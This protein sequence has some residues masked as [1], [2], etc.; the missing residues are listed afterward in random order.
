[1]NRSVFHL[2]GGLLSLF[3]GNKFVLFQSIRLLW[4]LNY[5]IQT[6]LTFPN[7]SEVYFY[8]SIFIFYSYISDSHFLFKDFYI[9]KI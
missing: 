9:L 6:C 4:K 5:M 3:F 8:Q 7:N 1:M 2:M